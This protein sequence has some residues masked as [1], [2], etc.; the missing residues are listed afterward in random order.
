MKRKSFSWIL[1]LF[2]ISLFPVY[3]AESIVYRNEGR[4]YTFTERTDLRRYDSGKYT[5]LFSREIR[6]FITAKSGGSQGKSLFSGIFYVFQQT[7]H[8]LMDVRERLNMAV[9]SDFTVGSDGFLS[10]NLDC[11]YPSFRNFP[12]LPSQKVSP[13]DSWTGESIRSVDP[14]ENGLFTHLVMQVSYKYVRRDKWK[15]HDVHVVSA[16]W[17][18]RYSPS[19]NEDNGISVFDPDLTGATGN[20]RAVLYI[21]AETGAMLFCQDTVD[22][23][24]LY[25]GGKSV[26]YKGTINLFTDYAPAVNRD[27]IKKSMENKFGSLGNVGL[28]ES[29]SGLVLTLSN[30]QFESDS[31]VLLPGE[32]GRLDL[33]AS[34]LKEIPGS[35]FLVTGHAAS[36]GNVSGEKALSEERACTIALALIE[37]GIESERIV[38]RGAGSSEPVASNSTPEGRAKNRRVEITV[39]E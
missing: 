21:S 1:P 29:G 24:F 16:S 35:T 25:R 31:A 17:A 11:G 15:N 9:E 33:I 2:F 4:N 28:K 13:G 20:H 39:L 12:S 14:L 26:S 5:G 10:M 18:T 34:V 6:S 36:T 19:L 32:S 38:C 3:G 27:G 7:K 23:T 8:K 30:L 22:E 37:R